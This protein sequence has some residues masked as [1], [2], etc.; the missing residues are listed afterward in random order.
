M[1]ERGFSVGREFVRYAQTGPRAPSFVAAR[2]QAGRA[3][4]DCM[5]AAIV[6][7]GS[8]AR[9]RTAMPSTPPVTMAATVNR[10]PTRYGGVP[11]QRALEHGDRVRAA[12]GRLRR[13]LWVCL[14][15]AVGLD[16]GRF[17]LGHR[18]DRPALYDRALMRGG[19]QQQPGLRVEL[20]D[21]EDE[22]GR[23]EHRALLVLEHRH[24]AERMAR[25][26]L[27]AARLLAAHGHEL[28]VGADLLERPDHAD[29]T[30]RPD[31]VVDAQPGHSRD[32]AHCQTPAGAK[33]WLTMPARVRPAAGTLIRRARCWRRPRIRRGGGA[34]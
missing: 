12:R 6:G 11:D 26:V 18:E 30:P 9:T 2:C 3:P 33:T 14:A 19:R 17:E 1:R 5:Y 24:P 22:R 7:D 29:R 15:L 4:S 25:A 20:G 27:R 34:T 16:R 13:C 8:I 23:L 10:E 32:A 31:A 21:V 28:V